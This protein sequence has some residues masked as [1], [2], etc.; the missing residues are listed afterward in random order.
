MLGF[1]HSHASGNPDCVHLLRLPIEMP[2]PFEKSTFVN[3]QFVTPPP[4]R[5]P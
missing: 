2:V 5:I 3:R 4:T 1:R